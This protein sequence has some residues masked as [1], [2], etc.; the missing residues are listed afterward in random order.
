MP[1]RDTRTAPF[2]ERDRSIG[3][4]RRRLLQYFARV[5]PR[6]LRFGDL[7]LDAR[8]VAQQLLQL[9]PA[10]SGVQIAAGELRVDLRAALRQRLQTPFELL[11]LLPQRL[12]ALPL[13]RFGA[14]AVLASL[15]A[16]HPV[17][18]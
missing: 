10:R 8:L 14:L 4:G 16:I 12:L 15:R 5:E 7:A 1:A 17:D 11:D 2:R 6:L 9:V 13:F 3:S 18:D